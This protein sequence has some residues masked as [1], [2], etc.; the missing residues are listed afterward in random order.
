MN[1]LV[2]SPPALKLKPNFLATAFL[3]AL[4]FLFPAQVLAQSSLKIAII[5]KSKDHITMQWN[6]L[7]TALRYTAGIKR[8]S[9]VVLKTV[10]AGTTTHTFGGLLPDREYEVFVSAELSSRETVMT[11]MYT[12]TEADTATPTR[13]SGPRSIQIYF[14]DFSISKDHFS[15]RWSNFR[16]SRGFNHP[17]RYHVQLVGGGKKKTYNFSSSPR[18]YNFGG[19]QE[20][21]V[22]ELYVKTTA[23][24][25][26]VIATGRTTVRT[27]SS[28]LWIDVASVTDDSISAQWSH[29]IFA[30]LYSLR[31]QGGGEDRTFAYA[32]S[33]TSRT[34]R[35]LKP[36]TKYTFTI[37]SYLSKDNDGPRQSASASTRTAPAAPTGTPTGTITPTATPVPTS[38]IAPKVSLYASAVTHNSITV[39]WSWNGKP[40]TIVPPQIGLSDSNH[41]YYSAHAYDNSGSHTFS[42]LEPNTRH[43]FSFIVF[44]K[45]G[46]PKVI[47][48]DSGRAFTLPVDA[49]AIPPSDTPTPNAT[50]T[51]PAISLAIASISKNHISVSWN[52]IATALQYTA[53][54]Q[55][56]GKTILKTVPAGTTT[57]TFGG[58]LADT[59]YEVFVSAELNSRK[60]VMMTMRTR[61]AAEPPTPTNTATPTPTDTATPTPTNTATPSNTPKP[62]VAQSQS[63]LDGELGLAF[64]AISKDHV[65]VVWGDMGDV[66]LYYL[67]IYGGGHYDF[68][69]LDQGK[70]SQTFG[71]LP[72]NTSFTVSFIVFQWD[73]SAEKITE[74]FSTLADGQVQAP[75]TNTPL[76]TATT[77]NT[78]AATDTPVPTATATNTATATDTPVPTATATNTAAATDTPLPQLQPLRAQAD[79]GLLTEIEAKI[80]RHR[81]GTGRADLA[82][83]FTAARDALTGSGS[84]P[85]ALALANNYDSEIWNRIRTALQAMNGQNPPPPPTNTPV[86]PTDTPVPPT[87]TP[88]PPTNTPVPPTN[89]PV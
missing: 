47:T 58:L 61:T 37:T 81:D 49:T 7:D 12:R 48:L 20:D 32:T 80:V 2:K 71:G 62:V 75:P 4:L 8:G 89:T 53:G 56:G 73:G 57:H 44:P 88:V 25:D 52:A 30:R 79:D 70:T 14:A 64:S 72:A 15:V 36:D 19:L 40:E 29:H 78:A 82:A 51:D 21:T 74:T 45:S 16:E 3:C 18:T 77:T 87:N 76:P 67:E 5:G 50:A 46:E 9:K 35:D 1:A 33:V 27:A 38:E 63:P 68:G 28:K 85:A 60:T 13:T 22:Y 59:A 54:I 34:F 66:M 69:L 17:Y 39:N 65:T 10:P 42:N 86:P 6:A 26:G 31:I 41:N 23:M 84:V 11:N 43:F 83:A 55:G 24:R